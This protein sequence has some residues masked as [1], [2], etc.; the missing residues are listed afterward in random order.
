MKKNLVPL[1]TLDIGKPGSSFALEI[2][3]NT[4]LP[5]H[6]LAE[7]KELAGKELAGFETLMRDVEKERQELALR[8][9]QLE[10]REQE[11][12]HLLEEYEVLN[13]ELNERK[14]LIIDKAKQEAQQL[15]KETNR[16]I[17]KTIRHIRENRAER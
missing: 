2:A 16:E 12:Q 6:V 9:K 13:T 17:E 4:G 1:Y 8:I 3:G 10:Q 5:G 11:V 15:L 14:K 7:G